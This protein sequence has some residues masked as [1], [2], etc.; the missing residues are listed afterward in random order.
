M[1]EA[2]MN[3]AAETPVEAVLRD[4]LAHGDVVLGTIA[5][6][7][8]H[9]LA[10]NDHS[11]FSDEIVARLR[12][13]VSHLAHQLLVAQAGGLGLSDPREFAMDNLDLLADDLTENSLVLGHCHALAIEAQ[14]AERLQRRNGI[15]QVLS[16]MIQSLIAST[17]AQTAA[18]AM[19]ALAAQARFVQTQRRMDLPLNELPG[20]LFHEVIIAWRQFAQDYDEQA[21]VRA[22]NALRQSYD[23]GKSRLGLMSRLVGGMGPGVRNALSLGHA[24]VAL[25]LTALASAS[26]QPRDLAT[27]S[28]NDRQLARLALSLRAAGLKPAEVEEQ[29]LYFH[30]DISLPEG[31]ETL[32]M[33]R[34]SALLADAVGS[35][36]A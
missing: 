21:I 23:E 14:L 8:G 25:F 31:F 33:D 16:P 3:Q 20:D 24:G 15:D 18:T 5:P 35:V 6:I 4:E 30:P 27:L 7:L 10:S 28:S 1:N 34:A 29:F 13:M 22:E 36:A 32:R 11:L 12:G 17:D 19:A 9:L 2:A 26:R